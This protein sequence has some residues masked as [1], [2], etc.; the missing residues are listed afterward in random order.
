MS[1]KMGLLGRKIGMT[2]VFHEDGTALGRHRGGRRALCRRRQAHP[3]QTRLLGGSARLR[4]EALRDWSPAPRPASSRRPG[5]EKPLR[6][7]R[8]VR[9]EPNDVEKYEVGKVLRAAEVF[10]PATSSTSSG[11]HQGQ[12]LPGRHEAP[13]HGRRPRDPRYARVLPPRRLDRLPSDPGAR[14]QGQAHVGGQMGN[15]KCTASDLVSSRC[16][17]TRTSS[18]SRA[19]SRARATAWSSSRAAPRTSRSTSCRAIKE[20]ESK[21]PMKASKK[22]G[23]SKRRDAQKS[24][25][26]PSSATPGTA[27]TRSPARRGRGVRGAIGLQARGDRQEAAAAPAG[28]PGARPGCRPGRGM[29]YALRWWGRTGRSSASTGHRCRTPDRGRA[30]ARGDIFTA[31][32]GAAGRA[33]RRSTSCCRT[34]RPTRPASAHRSG[35]FG[36]AVRGSAGPGRAA[37]G[38][39]RRFVGKIFQGPTSR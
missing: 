13:P 15:D 25:G 26:V 18:W 5:M 21:N 37:A 22:G 14:A 7:L 33:A 17:T 38:A 36:V 19:R 35:A 12:G 32:R 24:R 4:G 28:R 11:R 30:R 34:W 16:W 10:K 23:R 9:L 20:A 6:H 1:L 27:T 2:Q 29:Q 31:R 8:E 39:G 3:G